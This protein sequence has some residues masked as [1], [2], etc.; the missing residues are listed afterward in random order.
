MS[1]ECDDSLSA[2][3]GDLISW[4]EDGILNSFSVKT[5]GWKPSPKGGKVWT[6]ETESGVSVPASQVLKVTKGIFDCEKERASKTSNTDLFNNQLYMKMTDNL[7]LPPVIRTA[8]HCLVRGDRKNLEVAAFLID[9]RA[10]ELRELES[11]SLN[12]Q[13]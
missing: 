5:A 13:I 12:N 8:I 9:Q 11:A 4:N 7:V 10:R 3:P 1:V 6:Y 2:L